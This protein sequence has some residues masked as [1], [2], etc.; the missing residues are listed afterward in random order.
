MSDDPYSK[1]LGLPPGPRPPKAHELLGL[2]ANP[3]DAALIDQA[4]ARRMDQLDQFALSNDRAT[5]TQVQQLMNEVAKA[6]TKLVGRV[7]K[8]KPNAKTKPKRDDAPAAKT[9]PA[10]PTQQATPPTKPTPSARAAVSTPAPKPT[11][12]PVPAGDRSALQSAIA[13][14][15]LVVSG[16]AATLVVAYTV[17]FNYF[18]PD[19]LPSEPPPATAG[20][21]RDAGPSDPGPNGPAV[22]IN[23]E[24]TEADPGIEP[25]A[26]AT[27]PT[28]EE[29]AAQQAE[30]ERLALKKQEAEQER[31]A[32]ERRKTEQQ[33]EELR[34]QQQAEQRRMEAER[35]QAIEKQQQEE[36]R[37]QELAKQKWRDDYFAERDRLRG[38][39]K[40]AL[41]KRAFIEWNGGHQVEIESEFEN[42]RLVGIDLESKINQ[43]KNQLTDLT[44]LAGLQLR[45]L[46]LK[47]RK[48][49]TLAPLKGMP[50]ELLELDRCE[51]LEDISA[52]KGMPLKSVSISDALI[53]D[54]E[55]LRG[56]P[57][58][59][60]Y[61]NNCKQITT[62]APLKGAELASVHIS[63][64]LRL[65]DL[66][67]LEH[68]K[69]EK[70]KAVFYYNLGLTDLT[71]LKGLTFDHLSIKESGHFKS[72]EF[73]Q[74]ITVNVLEL[75]AE[76]VEDL[77]PLKRANITHMLKLDGDQ[78]SDLTPLS[79]LRCRYVTLNCPNLKSL[80]GLESMPSLQSVST[81]TRIPDK[82]VNR[83]KKAKPKLKVNLHY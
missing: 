7:P 76:Q 18:K 73:L 46:K 43:S 53:K 64:C 51:S 48:L 61:I 20:Y 47:G 72:L 34:R 58:K 38:D 23:P 16:W 82:E 68:M 71:A 5:R 36:L 49:K 63:N 42:G 57:L 32:A 1:W 41:I 55:P 19:P 79:R 75:E 13:F 60:F 11:P 31:L 25:A 12:Q 52:L 21:Q 37:R 6:R 50:L 56:M 30:Q 4:A 17:T 22:P 44:P 78:I 45:S 33:Q 40:V 14:W 15:V 81:Y 8:P 28:E 27:G 2:P 65:V 67:G 59:T 3:A 83:L 9:P 74:G 29:L 26:E 39:A 54:L 66:N 10:P 35:K 24:D 77:S 62:T 80:R 70:L 69:A